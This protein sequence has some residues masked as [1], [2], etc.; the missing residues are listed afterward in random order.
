MLTTNNSAGLFIALEGGEGAGKSTQAQNLKALLEGLGRNV[1]VTY[2][3]GGTALGQEIWAIVSKQQVEPLTELFLFATA[4]A[5]H[6]IEVIK[7]TLERGDV[8]I[9]DRYVHSSLAYQGYGRG[10]PLNHVRAVNH[11]ATQGIMPRAVFLLDVP[12]GV[13]LS[14]KGRAENDRIGSESSA[15]HTRVH[16]GYLA[17]ASEEPGTFFVVD[18]TLTTDKVTEQL[19]Q[20]V[21]PLLRV[22]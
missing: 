14:R 10:L 19:W 12:V 22:D 18:G 4:R 8:V 15:F 7:P 6:V 21:M 11:V 3:P 16:D 1:V 9:S 17:L 13:G 2:E 5:Q 20:Y